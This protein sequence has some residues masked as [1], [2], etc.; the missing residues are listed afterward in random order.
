MCRYTIK[1]IRELKYWLSLQ[2]FQKK[3]L[4]FYWEIIFLIL[5]VWA[6]N[7]LYINVELLNE[8]SKEKCLTLSFSKNEKLL[9]YLCTT[10]SKN[11]TRPEK[12]FMPNFFYLKVKLATIV[13]GDQKAPFSI[14]SIPRCRGGC[15]SFPLIAPLYPWSLTY[16]AEC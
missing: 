14:A 9:V 12:K 6:C 13:E 7:F 11:V 15:Y 1:S 2:F 5:V 4:I 16:I 3:L 10:G 8:Q